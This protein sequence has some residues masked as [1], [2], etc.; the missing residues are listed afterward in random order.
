[1]EWLN[2]ESLHRKLYNK[3]KVLHYAG[4]VKPWVDYEML[5]QEHENNELGYPCKSLFFRMSLYNIRVYYKTCVEIKD[6]LSKDF[7]GNI[8]KNIRLIDGVK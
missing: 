1:M 3:G 6:I 4:I 8:K 7:L 2:L 5:L